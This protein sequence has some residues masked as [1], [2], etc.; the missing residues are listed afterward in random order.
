V[1][2]AE[3][4]PDG[5]VLLAADLEGHE[6]GRAKATFAWGASSPRS[7]CELMGREVRVL[8]K[9][10][11][12]PQ[13][14]LVRVVVSVPAIV[15]MDAG[16]VVSL[17]KLKDWR[18]VPLREMLAEEL[19]CP[20]EVENDTNLA[21]QGEFSL[22]AARAE[23]N[24]VFITIGEGVG[25]GIFVD[26]KVCRGARWSAG[27]IGYLHVPSVSRESPRIRG[28]G[29]LE[30]MLGGPGI[31]QSWRA[32][33]MGPHGRVKVKRAVDVCDLAAAGNSRARKILGQKAKILADVVLDLSLILNPGMILFGGEV[34][35]HPVLMKEVKKLLAGSEF[36]VSSIK[37]G[38]LGTEAALWGGI[39]TGLESGIAGLLHTA[40][41]AV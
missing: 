28:Y 25:A 26:G 33:G 7:I 2:A 27:E 35:S 29:R 36:G 19:K 17:S 39:A 23:K 3:L 8:L 6:M 15:D 40:R 32:A 20:V 38:E 9:K 14:R 13:E 21:A 34:G 10:L 31:L 11:K 24:F 22:G 41:V 1:V 30:K 18:D 37:L 12:K 16:V 4:G 5:V